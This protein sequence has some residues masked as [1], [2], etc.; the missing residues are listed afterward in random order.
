VTQENPLLELK[1]LCVAYGEHTVLHDVSL[2][3]RPGE[4]HCIAGESGSGKSTILKAILGLEQYGADIVGGS[5]LFAGKDIA[6]S[7]TRNNGS[8]LLGKEIGLV[9]QNPAASFNPLRS[10]RTQFRETLR[11]HGMPYQDEDVLAVFSALGLPPELRVLDSCPYEVSGGMCQRLA[12]V[13]LMLLRPRLLL[14]DEVTSALDVTTQKQ[15][16]D[17]LLR[18]RDK[19]GM[20][21][22]LVTHNLGLASY[23]ADSISIIKDG[24]CVEQGSIELLRAPRHAYTRKLTGDVANFTEL[25]KPVR[26]RQSDGEPIY[27]AQGIAKRYRVR[28]NTVEALRGVS[29]ALHRGEILG[30]VGESGSGKSTILKQLACM[31]KPDA[32]CVIFQGQNLTEMK[33]KAGLDVLRGQ[34]QMI[35]QDAYASFNPR[36]TI[37]QSIEENIRLAQKRNKPT[38]TAEELAA[39]VGL[40][41]ELLDRYPG[42]LSGGQ[43]QRMAVARALAASP[44]VLLCDEITS[45]LDVTVQ[46]EVAE[47]LVRL[48][49]ERNLSILFIS[50][51]L[52]LVHSFCDRLLVL[53]NGAVTEE[54]LPDNVIFHSRHEYTRKLV[55][56]VLIPGVSTQSTRGRS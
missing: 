38:W 3:L 47:L 28:G 4:I 8:S 34:V 45:A 52:A 25:L 51:D 49:E 5:I 53:K 19:T 1:N 40:S 30:I 39:Q 26:S 29:F 37:R 33:R 55:D 44:E 2:S 36:R 32:G 43:C 27:A 14:C 56:A 48:H 35:F 11:S 54:G 20:A 16:A 17:E 22:L 41:P 10:F 6:Q 15:V 21:I 7:R 18:L 23:M 42:R 46:R 13:L 24:R 12:I 9:A 50:H 31:E